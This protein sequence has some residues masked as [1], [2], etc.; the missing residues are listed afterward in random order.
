MFLDRAG[1]FSGTPPADVTASGFT[2]IGSSQSGTSS[3]GFFSERQN[4]WYKL[5]LGTETGALTGMSGT[6][7]A[8]AM[9]VFRGNVPAALITVADVAGQITNANPTAQVVDASGGV[10]P[11]IVIGAYGSANA[12]DPR[13]F[14]T[15]KDGEINPSA[16]LYLAYKIYNSSPADSSIDM[17][18]E[19][20]VNILQSCYIQMA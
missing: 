18:D 4:L 6:A 8:K 13:T 1:N 11:L 12:V 14:S 15:T 10:A 20:D 16:F 7:N 19:G 2:R 9:Y 5:A 17:D 3:S